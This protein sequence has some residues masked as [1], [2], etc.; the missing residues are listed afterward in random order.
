MDAG[1]VPGAAVDSLKWHSRGFAGG[2]HLVK[3]QLLRGS[4][5]SLQ[6]TKE[7]M[8][9]QCNCFI[10]RHFYII[11]QRGPV[12]KLKLT[13]GVDTIRRASLKAACHPARWFIMEQFHQN[14]TLALV[15]PRLR[16]PREKHLTLGYAKLSFICH[17]SERSLEHVYERDLEQLSFP[18]SQKWS[19]DSVNSWETVSVQAHP[20]AVTWPCWPR[21]KT[22]S[23]WYCVILKELAVQNSSAGVLV[24][25]QC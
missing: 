21:Q 2:P 4:A 3:L 20:V 12:K 13:W 19:Q 8:V 7:K 9:N 1:S 24:N 17:L 18:S 15:A 25:C 16:I 11:K 22:H 23:L 10:P 14:L 6:S 5:M